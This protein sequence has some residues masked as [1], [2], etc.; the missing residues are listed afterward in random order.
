MARTV[1]RQEQEERISQAVWEVL[2]ESGPQNL[3]LRAVAERAGCT[4]GLVLH[5]FPDK[6]ALLAHARQL[7]HERTSVRMDELAAE[8]LPPQ[9]ELRELLMQAN[10]S[11]SSDKQ[12]DSR[13]WLGFLAS[14]LGDPD[15]TAIHVA[16]NRDFIARVE[17]IVGRARP[18]W[19]PQQVAT[20]A[21]A[22]ISLVEGLNVLATADLEHY[23]P[24]H[25]GD[26]IEYV[27]RALDLDVPS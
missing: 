7:L 13:V 20:T 23:T 4:T 5:T 15:L 6:K 26:A 22:L 25:Q 12:H 16:A 17:Q 9:A 14:A 27:L 1:N 2:A 21:T 8:G 19:G 3:T 10:L 18:A 11:H 24:E